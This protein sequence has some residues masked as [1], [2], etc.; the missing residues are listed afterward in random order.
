MPIPMRALVIEDNEDIAEV[1]QACVQG[2][3]ISADAVGR[4]E[5]G[6]AA[7]SSVAYDMLI[8]DLNLPGRDGLDVLKSIRAQGSEIPVLILSARANVD[9]RVKGLDSG[10]DDYLVKPF[11]LSEL[12][13]RVRALLRRQ[14]EVRSQVIEV[15]DLS[16][17]QTTRQCFVGE[18]LLDLSPRERSV[19]EVLIRSKNRVH[20]KE[21]IAD[22][23]SNFEAD[24][25][26]SSIEIYVHRLRKKI[27]DSGAHIVTTRGLGYTLE[28]SDR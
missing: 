2:M 6:L 26:A 17:D 14:Q 11:D 15:A 16:F 9:D 4:G 18:A 19:L 27:S 10:A 12:E 22:H 25:A 24:V 13:A 28:A 5:L 1:V 7:L 8:L 20:S 3:G 23:I 21:S